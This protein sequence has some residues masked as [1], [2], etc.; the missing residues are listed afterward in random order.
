MRH[1][2]QK[3]LASVTDEPGWFEYLT[4]EQHLAFTRGFTEVVELP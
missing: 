1:R 4:V 3:Q 2:S